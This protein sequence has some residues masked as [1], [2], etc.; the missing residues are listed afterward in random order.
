MLIICLSIKRV[1]AENVLRGE[2]TRYAML[3][4]SEHVRWLGPEN[5]SISTNLSKYEIKSSLNNAQLIIDHLTLADQ[6]DYI[7]ADNRTGEVLQRYHLTVGSIRTVLVPF[8]IVI[9][10]IL[11]L[12]PICWFLG[13]KYSGVNQ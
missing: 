11:L 4:P 2:K 3:C 12:L 1:L 10:S 5:R 8:L 7:C 9:L 13:R 6:G